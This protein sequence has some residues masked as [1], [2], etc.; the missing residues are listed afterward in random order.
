MKFVFHSRLSFRAASGAA[1]SN[2]HKRRAPENR[3]KY[4]LKEKR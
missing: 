2:Q 1:N 3:K 4:L